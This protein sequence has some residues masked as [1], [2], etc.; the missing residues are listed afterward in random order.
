MGILLKAFFGLNSRCWQRVTLVASA[1]TT[2][3]PIGP[4][5]APRG[6]VDPIVLDKQLAPGVIG[7]RDDDRLLPGALLCL[8]RRGG[9]LSIV[10]ATR[11]KLPSHYRAGLTVNVWWC[12]QDSVLCIMSKGRLKRIERV[13]YSSSCASM[14]NTPRRPGV[15]DQH[16][17]DTVQPTTQGWYCHLNRKQT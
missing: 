1:S 10:S 2:D 13:L 3:R 14:R 9:N 8:C 5:L 12:W 16:G 6:H 4:S 17:S 11:R 15:T 7:Q